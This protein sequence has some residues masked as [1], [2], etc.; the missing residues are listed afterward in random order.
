M[1][2]LE[3]ISH[4]LKQLK[5]IDFDLAYLAALSWTGLKPISRYEKPLDKTAIELLS[6]IG[7]NPQVV[8]ERASEREVTVVIFGRNEGYLNIYKEAFGGKQ[9][10]YTKERVRL[11]G[12]LFG[13]PPCCIEYFINEKK[14]KINLPSEDHR[15]VFHT[16]VCENCKITPLLINEY[17]KVF[18]FIEAL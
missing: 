17:R 1:Y 14:Q 18:E 2:N 4:Q 7:L 15:L 16:A 10:E 11:E 3:N 12:F 5:E 9:I 6:S 13:Y 8:I